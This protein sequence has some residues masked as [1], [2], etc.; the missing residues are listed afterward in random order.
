MAPF[1]FHGATHDDKPSGGACPTNLGPAPAAAPS[2]PRDRTGLPG[3]PEPPLHV[4]SRLAFWPSSGDV[5]VFPS[6]LQHGVVPAS[7]TSTLHHE[8]AWRPS[9]ASPGG[10]CPTRLAFAA[11][12]FLSEEA[13]RRATALGG[14]RRLL[15]QYAAIGLPPLLAHGCQAY[16]GWGGKRWGLFEVAR[17]VAMR[18]AE[19]DRR[20]LRSRLGR[21]V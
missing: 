10:T 4:Q 19:R 2:P 16:G 11:N 18:T 5:L 15:E 12:L 21:S 14:Q 8:R 3:G 9:S 20:E 13:K 17:D 6:W 1:V 7:S